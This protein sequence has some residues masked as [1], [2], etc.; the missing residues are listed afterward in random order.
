M[1]PLTDKENRPYEEQEA[2]HTCD[3]KFC[4]DKDDE[5]YE[6]KRK[7]KDNYY[8]TRKFRGATHS[9]CNLKYKIPKDVPI[10]IHNASYDTRFLINQ[11]AEE[12]KDK[13]NC[14]NIEK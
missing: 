13:L 8:Y 6:N 9:K 4:M 3:E 10:L 14:K 11:L 1:I 5:N 2:C 7:V 12:F